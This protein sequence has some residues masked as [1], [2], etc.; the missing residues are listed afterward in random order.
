MARYLFQLIGEQAAPN[1]LFLLEPR[2]R[3]MD[4]FCFITTPEMEQRHILRNLLLAADVSI[5]QCTVLRVPAADPRAV[6]EVLR[7]LSLQPSDECHVNLTGGT[8]MMGIGTFAYFSQA[9][10]PARLY[11]VSLGQNSYRC[12]YPF[13][14]EEEWP[15]SAQLPVATYLSSYGVELTA[16]PHLFAPSATTQ[17]IYKEY[18]RQQ[19]REP[20]PLYSLGGKIRYFSKSYS[21]GTTPLDAVPG[22]ME[23]LDIL[24]L[25]LPADGFLS[26]EMHH[27]LIGGWL[28]EWIYHQVMAQR[29]LSPE[30]IALQAGIRRR[31]GGRKGTQNELDLLFIDQGKL[32]VLECKTGI[33]RKH[34]E[35]QAQYN[36]ALYKLAALRSDFGLN[37]HMIFLTISD[38]LRR[39]K[40]PILTPF[41]RRA[42][43][44]NIDVWD[45]QR[46]SEYGEEWARMLGPT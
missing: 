46:L 44:L 33:G 28:E 43:L 42:E 39:G 5:E 38:Q 11:Y 19:V 2:F 18:L 8:K 22:L 45:Q 25:P 26:A 17:L 9:K 7:S 12:I 40:G 27:Y 29:Q 23:W 1:L 31:E 32:Y 10:V 30:A 36:K 35:V 4:H 20:Y 15:F 41:R 3:A 16:A 34:G 21:L 6:W 13:G 24:E 37:V 14:Q